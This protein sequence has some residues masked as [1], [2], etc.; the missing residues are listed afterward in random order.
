[1]DVKEERPKLL[2]EH[3]E[4][5]KATLVLLQETDTVLSHAQEVLSEA[6]IKLQKATEKYQER[7]YGPT[8]SR[9]N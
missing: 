7:L 8:S 4:A 2:Q 9:S 1:M 3:E 5:H 6:R